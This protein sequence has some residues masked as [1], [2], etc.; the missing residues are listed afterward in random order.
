MP[1]KEA[2]RGKTNQSTAEYKEDNAVYM[3]PC[4]LGM[5]LA[6]RE[7]ILQ[8]KRGPPQVRLEYRQIEASLPQT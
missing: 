7:T 5:R 2:G 1:T 6:L 4:P 3:V 8:S